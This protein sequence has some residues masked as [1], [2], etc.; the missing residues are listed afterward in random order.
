MY[1]Y[2]YFNRIHLCIP[3]KEIRFLHKKRFGDQQ[4][5][6]HYTCIVQFYSANQTQ[7]SRLSQSKALQS[8]CLILALAGIHENPS[9]P[10]ADHVEGITWI[11]LLDNHLA[12]WPTCNIAMD[13]VSST[14]MRTVYIAMCTVFI[15]CHQDHHY[16]HHRQLQ[17]STCSFSIIVIF[18][19]KKKLCSS[20]VKIHWLKS[21]RNAPF[22]KVRRHSETHKLHRL[23]PQWDVRLSAGASL[24]APVKKRCF[25][26]DVAKLV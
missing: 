17:N 26:H 24:K 6:K 3:P 10:R 13:H 25:L 19:Q 11:P 2:I 18:H 4:K 14:L 5:T 20:F 21:L 23:R 7:T 1:I 8:R 22:G 16:H 15:H 9:F 12:F